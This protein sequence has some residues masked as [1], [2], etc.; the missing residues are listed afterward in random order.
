MR[1]CARAHGARRCQKFVVRKQS[2]SVFSD[3]N[4]IGGDWPSG[5]ALTLR[6]FTLEYTRIRRETCTYTHIPPLRTHSGT[7]VLRARGW[8]CIGYDVGVGARFLYIRTCSL[9]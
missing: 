1:A 3:K 5:S 6:Y 9:W 4:G 7:Y 8:L 2:S